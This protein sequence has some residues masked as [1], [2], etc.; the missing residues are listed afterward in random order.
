MLSSTRRSF[1]EYDTT[2]H[3]QDFLTYGCILY[4]V[5][6]GLSCI[7]L[8]SDWFMVWNLVIVIAVMMLV[9]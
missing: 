6:I 8:G 5:L 9:H 2:L 1:L 3:Q 4:L 7:M